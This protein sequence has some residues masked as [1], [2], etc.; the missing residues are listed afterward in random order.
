LIEQIYL[1]LADLSSPI[2]KKIYMGSYLKCAS[3]TY[4]F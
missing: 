3:S 2:K 4:N 1:Y